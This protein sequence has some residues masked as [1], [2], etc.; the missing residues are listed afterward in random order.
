MRPGG[1]V[2]FRLVRRSRMAIGD[3][4][5]A[6][7]MEE[8]PGTSRE[9]WWN[10]LLSDVEFP[11]HYTSPGFFREIYFE[12]LKPFAIGAYEPGGELGGLLTCVQRGSQLICGNFG[13]PQV[14][15]RRGS[16]PERTGEIL[17]A[18]LV[19]QAVR[20]KC[21]LITVTCWAP[22]EG[23]KRIGF[24]ETVNFAPSGTV[25]LDLT[26]GPDVLFKEFSATS[27]NQIRH[28]IREN[29]EVTPC[30]VD[31]DFDDYY[32]LHQEWCEFKRVPATPYD[33]QRQA[34]FETAHRL[35]L[36]ARHQGKVIGSSAFR[37]RL[38]GVVEYAANISRR[39][40]TKIRQND[41][42]LWRAIE[43]AAKAGGTA[44]SMGSAQL[45]AQKFGGKPHPTYRYRLDLTFMRRHDGR[46]QIRRAALRMYHKLP[47]AMQRVAKRS[48]V[49]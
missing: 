23:F 32:Q 8:A 2:P 14:V 9:S 31:R 22:N 25:L 46:E 34:L 38:P 35:I 5:S 11:S 45:F 36:I 15:I 28:A 21:E 33:V 18:A 13:T 49:R 41:L 47:A 3:E 24:K 10:A 20:R 48:L 19:R 1:M 30:D 4:R 16:N 7:V 17:A 27:R 26:R 37:F 40:E 12:K 39:E 43:W 6:C 44:F 29:V 42:L